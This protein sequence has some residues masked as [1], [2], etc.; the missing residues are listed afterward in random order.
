MFGLAAIPSV[1]QFI[2]FLFMPETPRWLI[3]K[4]HL[5]KARMVLHRIHGMSADVEHEVTDINNSV[6]QS[7]EHRM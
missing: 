4:G 3:T 2:A 5:D 7:E 1:I 6:Q